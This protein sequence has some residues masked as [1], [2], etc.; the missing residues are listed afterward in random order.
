[1]SAREVGGTAEIPSL[2][3]SIAA[4]GE[5]SA[6]AGRDVKGN[7]LG[8]G[9]QVL[10][11]DKFV[12][13]LPA[14]PTHTR[15]LPPPVVSGFTSRSSLQGALTDA[16]ISAPL[17]SIL[18]LDGFPGSGKSSLVAL[19]CHERHV[20][21][22]FEGRILWLTVGQSR[23]G[24]ELAEY[25]GD[26]CE[27]LGRRRPPTHD[28][29]LAGAAF[30][31]VLDDIGEV[32][33]VID[34]VW[35]TEQ[36]DA[37]LRGAVTC[38][39]VFTARSAGVVPGATPVGV[40][41]MTRA[42]SRETLLRDVPH[43][44]E[45][46]GDSLIEIARGWPLVLGLLNAAL[47][48]MARS[49]AAPEH[50]ADWVV[51]IARH[52]GSYSVG[53]AGGSTFARAVEASLGLLPANARARFLELGVFRDDVP[54]PAAAVESLWRAT[55]ALDSEASRSLS[56]QLIDLRLA[57]PA[58]KDD[59]PCLSLHDLL[60]SYLRDTLGATDVATANAALVDSWRREYLP[61]CEGG[62]W[63]AIGDA[64]RFVVEHLPW[65]LAAAGG[66]AE[67]ESLATD[68]R[69][70]ETQVRCLGS[71]VP[72]IST[73]EG[74]SGPLAARL[75]GFLS[76][77]LHVLLPDVPSV[78]ASTLLG[79][80]EQ[81]PGLDEVARRRRQSLS[82]P[83]ALPAWRLP[84]LRLQDELQHFGPVGDC[85]V[86]PDGRLLASA[87]DDGLVVI[88]D[89]ASM[90]PVR[91]LTGHRYRA[92][93]CSFSPSG[94]HLASTGM[95]GTV[96]VWH[97]AS[98]V[99]ERVLGDRRARMLGACWSNDGRSIAS[100]DTLGRVTVWDAKNGEI[101]IQVAVAGVFQ[102]SC[103]FDHSD[104]EIIACGEDGSVRSWRVS[105]GKLL[106]DIQVHTTRLR[107]VT[108]RPE[109]SGLAV[110]GNDGFL[111]IMELEEQGSQWSVRP[112]SGHDRRVR[113]C[114][115]SPDGSLLASAGEDRTVRIWDARTGEE[116]HTL[117]GHTDWVGGCAFDPSGSLLYSCGGDTS[118]RAWDT[119][120]GV[121]AAVAVGSVVAT[122]S[123]TTLPE[124]DV[125]IGRADGMVEQLR[126]SDG[127]PLRGWHAHEG[128]VFGVAWS[129]SLVVTGGADGWVRGWTEGGKA[130]A[131]IRAWGDSRVMQ[132][133]SGAASVGFVTEDGEVAVMSSDGA[134][135][136][137]ITAAHNDFVL[138]CAFSSDGTVFASAGDDSSVA[139]WD[140]ADLRPLRRFAADH[141]MAFWSL[142]FAADGSVLVATGE[143]GGLMHI[144]DLRTGL[145]ATVVA[146]SGRLSGCA[147]DP[148]SNW[149]AV[150]GEDGLL[151]VWDLRSRTI[152]TG[153][154]VAAPL[155]RVVWVSADHGPALVSA[156]AAGT[157]RFDLWFP[158]TDGPAG[159]SE[160][161]ASS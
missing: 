32:L 3:A 47:R 122:E 114:T 9:S 89:A 156:G 103:V 1:M 48:R 41:E 148:T 51:S 2:E 101:T 38:V 108:V 111:A 12:L 99:Q 79:R 8:D 55:G 75:A 84:D 136:R 117:I 85:A 142:D 70:I 91:A 130:A 11:I 81:E 60:R 104:E 26:L 62:A 80:V 6:A 15:F 5:G 74:C 67:L 7:A 102:W 94:E 35:S 50:V 160:A 110:A 83:A 45:A 128:R 145:E 39:R 18:A 49:G 14:Q 88:W 132:V 20:V 57:D 52:P 126:G 24:P 90:S 144:W 22:R 71:A 115:F 153:V 10:N 40:G 97:V 121:C 58:F 141:D 86:S 119:S 27:M 34:D 135:L 87:S 152:V 151:T 129:G 73:L 78:L 16:L 123:C 30:G 56:Y 134:D 31:E 65:H 93:A 157:Y 118:L 17:G 124:G 143:P 155:R 54:I 69:W 13:E 133:S 159:R 127:K 64:Q 131:S 61:Q 21:E 147:I 29:L 77:N 98:G 150:C 37:F 19:V 76:D 46:L 95:D 149:V 112:L 158:S 137:R 106:A 43:G 36:A 53:G 66:V 140:A 68:L 161:E 25:L 154:R 138:G 105:D 44:Y 116:R 82:A 100:V 63:W 113:W 146:G 125:L 28:P 96:R 23:V 33:V 72:S 92:R 109:G 4:S 42:E 139:L 59:S 120:T 107:C